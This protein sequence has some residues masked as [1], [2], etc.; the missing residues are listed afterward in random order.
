MSGAAAAP[1][2]EELAWLARARVLAEEAR[3]QVSPNPL[4]G[5]VVARGGQVLGEG[6][7]AGPGLPHAEV[8]ALL[9]AGDAARGATVA[10]T[11]EPCSHR[12]RT[13]PCTDAL[14]AA[15]VARV[16]VGCRD[17][18]ECDRAGGASTLVAAGVEVAFA[19]GA[20]EAACR[21]QN[22]PF[23][24]WARLGR[25][26]VTLKLATSLDGKIA[27]ASGESRWISGPEARALVHRWRA[28]Q[29]AVAVGSGTALADDPLLTARDVP[30]APRQ[31]LRV[32]FDGRASL[33][34]DSQ[35]ARTSAEVPVLVLAG[36]EAA[37]ERRA[38]LSAAGVE[39][40]LVDAAREE[41]IEAGLAELGRRGV[42]S[43][44]VEGGAGLAAAMLDAGVV[45]RVAWVLAPTLIGGAGAPGAVGDPGA[46][47]LADAPR[48]REV[49]VERLGE[50]VLVSGRLHDVPGG[51]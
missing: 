10:C 36:P 16:V 38:A 27:T 11:L 28:E 7:H 48:L 6:H 29:D 25:P 31:P 1:S 5:A 50:D 3:G 42:Q 9:A 14:L 2:P 51:G 35:L 30:G 43:L 41:R 49:A 46:E 22:G 15:G 33:P 21:R 23:M 20:D 26:E 47:R 12:G 19:T 34:S 4:V 44:L 24:T 45:D 17:P 37:P 40:A 8:E 13:P 18:L 32:V 39:V